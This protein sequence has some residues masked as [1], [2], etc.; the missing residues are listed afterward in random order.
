MEELKLAVNRLKCSTIVRCGYLQRWTAVSTAVFVVVAV[1]RWITRDD[2][3]SKK[4]FKM[5]IGGEIVGISFVLTVVIVDNSIELSYFLPPFQRSS[6][7]STLAPRKWLSFSRYSSAS[8]TFSFLL[9]APQQQQPLSP[10]AP[11]VEWELWRLVSRLSWP[12]QHV[13]HFTKDNL[14]ESIPHYKES[15]VHFSNLEESSGTAPNELTSLIGLS[16]IEHTH[17][18]LY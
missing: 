16:I 1:L 7:S 12:I 13:D 9:G 11:V 4:S 5:K 8:P 18:R 2:V 15:S 3:H 14:S 6:Y 10:S 17:A